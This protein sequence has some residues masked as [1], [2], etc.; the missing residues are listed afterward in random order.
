MIDRWEPNA[1]G[2]MERYMTGDY[3]E[4]DAYN[5]ASEKLHQV[6]NDLK[7]ARE[8]IEEL[9]RQLALKE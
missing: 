1:K 4:Y 5:D 2:E 3:V 6:E 8:E 9:K 7:I